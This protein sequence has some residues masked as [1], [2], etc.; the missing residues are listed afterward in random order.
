MTLPVWVAAA[1]RAALEAL[2]GRPFF[3]QQLIELSDQDKSL[4]VPVSSVVLMD[5]G[6]QAIGI[7]HCDSG[8]GLD[9]TRGMEIWTFVQCLEQVQR[10]ESVDIDR[11]VDWLQLVPGHGVGKFE[12]TDELCISAFARELL[13]INLRKLVPTHCILKLEI[14]FPRGKE[15]A[16]RTSNQA[17][18]VVDGLALIG[19]TA[20]AQISASPEK[21]NEVL[22]ELDIYCSDS[23]FSGRLTVVLG[24]NGFELAR[25][26]GV[27]A[28]S[29]LKTGN[30]LGPVLVAAAEKGVQELLV[31][32]YHGKLVKL[33]GG[34][35]HTHH[36]LAD[37]RMEILAALAVNE[38]LP[39]SLI[40]A[41][42][43]AKS[44]EEAFI[45]LDAKHPEIARSLWFK[46]A[47]T[48]ETRSQSYIQRYGNWPMKIGAVFFDRQRSLRW[49]GPIGLRQ[50][51]ALG[52][53]LED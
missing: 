11:S 15:L 40:Q 14:I 17:F 20:E 27:P 44:V 52:I 45:V 35:F 51:D 12:G 41:I 21:L 23:S 48:V 53:A 25:K 32:G 43:K 6:K 19:T 31:F 9:L 39:I 7:S 4:L 24:E 1:A 3:D 18:G 36:H 37:G 10:S 22:E 50:V 42:S 26:R 34:I 33:A 29:L 46:I 38:G 2:L 28:K 16:C 13:E 49:A 30:W 47:A 5:G 8:L